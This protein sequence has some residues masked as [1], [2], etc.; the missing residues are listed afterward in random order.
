MLAGA[1]VVGIDQGKL[2]QEDRP[3]GMAQREAS[4]LQ[5]LCV[6][7]LLVALWQGCGMHVAC[8][9][10]VVLISSDIFSGLMLFYS[11]P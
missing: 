9:I 8:D 5:Q 2:G 4:Q 3:V 1:L 6:R 7:Q 10:W 11:S